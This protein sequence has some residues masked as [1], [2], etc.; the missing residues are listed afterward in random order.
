MSKDKT[1]VL[2]LRF[3]YDVLSQSRL[4]TDEMS[5]KSTLFL[6]WTTTWPKIISIILLN[7]HAFNLF[8]WNQ[9]EL[10]IMLRM[11][12]LR[13][14]IYHLSDIVS[15]ITSVSRIK[16]E[17]IDHTKPEC[18]TFHDWGLFLDNYFYDILSNVTYNFVL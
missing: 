15:E 10:F 5:G 8:T 18:A 2:S 17:F 6:F 1:Y 7:T 3:S 4:E 16:A 12:L 11:L 9:T 13:K 14:N